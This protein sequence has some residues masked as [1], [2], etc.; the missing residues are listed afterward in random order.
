MSDY[1]IDIDQ[2]QIAVSVA[3]DFQENTWTFQMSPGFRAGAGKYMI[4]KLMLD[5]IDQAGSLIKQPDE[6]S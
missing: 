4:I 6:A 1:V 3:A 2:A 5:A